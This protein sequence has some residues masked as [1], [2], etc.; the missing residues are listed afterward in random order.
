M[1]LPARAEE[2]PDGL[3]DLVGSLRPSRPGG[4]AAPP[5]PAESPRATWSE[6]GT[7]RYLGAPPGMAF[8]SPGPIAGDP[9][10]AA[11]RFIDS[12]RRRFGLENPA[13]GLRVTRSRRSGARHFVRLQQTF[14][15]VPVFGAMASVQ[16]D[17]EGGVEAL[18]ADFARI[19]RPIDE[20][21]ALS[22]AQAAERA[23][24]RVRG[25]DPAGT[26]D[27]RDPVLHLWAPSVL[28]LDGEPRWVWLVDVGM[29]SGRSARLLIDARDGTVVREYPLEYSA[30]DRQI[31]DAN[32]TPSS[33]ATLVRDEGDPPCGIADADAAYD[34]LASTYLFYLTHH[35]RDGYDGA[36]G[37]LR[38]SV[39]YC[40]STPCPWQ[41]AVWD[42]F[43]GNI[44]FGEGW[45]VDDITGHEFTHGV[46]E[47]ESGLIYE[48]ASGA[49]N[50]S[51]SDVWGEFVDLSDGTGGFDDPALRW[52]IGEALPN[53]T[54]R[55]MS[56]PPAYQNPDRLGSPLY[57]PPAANPSLGN[58][59][60]GVHNNSGINNKL[61]FLLTDGGS[62]NGFSVYGKG[63]AAVADLY[64]E[65]NSNLL[66]PAADWVDLFDALMQAAINLGWSSADRINLRTACNAVEIGIYVVDWTSA[67]AIQT[68]VPTC[69]G[70]VGPYLTVLTGHNAVPWGSTLQI[71]AGTYPESIT[72]SKRLRLAAQGGVVRVGP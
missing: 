34:Q 61:C 53:F 59:Y 43:F 3:G 49:M 20:R 10:A 18:V 11:R 40:P 22:A 47:N 45:T 21:P 72:L 8:A 58:D 15:E 56:D 2:P 9:E 67:C 17:A 31:Y 46:T 69:S 23:R 24:D 48:N 32:N 13:S 60:G 71:R 25:S 6:R 63:V 66:V 27:L 51:L 1:A 36:G 68:G 30:L 16:L 62:F 41:N 4:P 39:R 12:Q 14:S 65:A 55:S 5:E 64:Y 52:L 50:E 70:L 26:V 57:T 7:L 28:G 44:K 19:D 42:G 37:V 38:A 54:L 35:A 29:R 33:F